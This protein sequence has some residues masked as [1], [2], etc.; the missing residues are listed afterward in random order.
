MSIYKVGD[1]VRFIGWDDT[2]KGLSGTVVCT[3]VEAEEGF[4]LGIAFEEL[5]GGRNGHD[6]GG[7]INRQ[8]GWWCFSDELQLINKKPTKIKWL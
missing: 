5:E 7:Q 6:L 8:I 2:V 3:E 1:R 4:G